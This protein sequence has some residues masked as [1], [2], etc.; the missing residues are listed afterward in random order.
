M[1]AAEESSSAEQREDELKQM[2]NSGSEVLATVYCIMQICKKCN[3]DI[4]R[5]TV[6]TIILLKRIRIV[7]VMLIIEF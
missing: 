4:Q 3:T 6:S 1:L 5:C 2:K 7:Y